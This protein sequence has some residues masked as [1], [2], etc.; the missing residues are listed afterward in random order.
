MAE[1]DRPV[2]AGGEAAEE[3]RPRVLS[4]RIRTGESDGPIFPDIPVPNLSCTLRDFLDS[5]LKNLEVENQEEEKEEV[6]EL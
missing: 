3:S 2:A 5:A 1:E 6:N 4:L